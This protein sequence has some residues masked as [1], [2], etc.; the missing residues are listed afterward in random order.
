MA[1]T[2]DPAEAIARYLER[3]GLEVERSRTGDTLAIRSSDPRAFAHEPTVRLPG[4][5][6]QTYLENLGARLRDSA[7]PAAEA[8]SLTQINVLEELTTDHGGGTNH[9]RT[10]GFRR[11]RDGRPELF[12]EKD[13][14]EPSPYGTGDDPLEWRAERPSP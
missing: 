8:L 5:I 10:V 1:A 6:L 12:V 7:D 3:N 2:E 14:P 11:G 13:P 9:T 4:R